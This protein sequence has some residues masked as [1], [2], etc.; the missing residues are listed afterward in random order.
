VAHPEQLVREH[1]G[2]HGLDHGHGARHDARVVS[3]AGN[4]VHVDAVPADLRENRKKLY[5]CQ[6]SSKFVEIQVE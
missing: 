1:D 6:A 4:E 5:F 3:S 2:N